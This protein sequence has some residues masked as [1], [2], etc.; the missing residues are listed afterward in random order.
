GHGSYLSA[1]NPA[2]YPFSPHFKICFRARGALRETRRRPAAV[3]RCMVKSRRIL[4]DRLALALF[5]P[6]C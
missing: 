4:S 6:E 5:I 3:K 1:P 2:P